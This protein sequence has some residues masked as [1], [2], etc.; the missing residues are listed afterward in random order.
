M[1]IAIVTTLVDDNSLCAFLFVLDFVTNYLSGA[2]VP[3]Q[4]FV[5]VPLRIG[6]S[7]DSVKF[8]DD[9]SVA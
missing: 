3:V 6:A 5:C 4:S 9:N 2:L 7:N 1:H 8:D